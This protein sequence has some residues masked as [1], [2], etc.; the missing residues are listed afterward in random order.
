M[1]IPFDEIRGNTLG[2]DWVDVANERDLAREK[3]R[4]FFSRL[5]FWLLWKRGRATIH[6]LSWGRLRF[7]SREW[8]F[9]V[10]AHFDVSCSDECG[11]FAYYIESAKSHWLIEEL[12]ASDKFIRCDNLA[13][14]RETRLKKRFKKHTHTHIYITVLEILLIQIVFILLYN[15]KQC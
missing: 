4:N 13:E 9:F 6:W 7:A 10:T 14:S 15:L 11:T 12:V 2:P 1:K 3:T 8:R 5:F